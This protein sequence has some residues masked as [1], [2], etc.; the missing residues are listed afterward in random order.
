MI[1]AGFFF[2]ELENLSIDGELENDSLHNQTS[3]MH[4]HFGSS[5]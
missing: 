2:H 3:I 5:H 4:T 1:S